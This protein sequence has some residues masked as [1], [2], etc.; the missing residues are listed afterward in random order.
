LA[1]ALPAAILCPLSIR[2]RGS[3][4]AVSRDPGTS[5]RYFCRQHE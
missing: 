1:A 3:K 4:S 2:Q 5:V